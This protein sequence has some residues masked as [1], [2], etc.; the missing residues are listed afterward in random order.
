M[1]RFDGE[2]HSIY[3]LVAAQIREFEESTEDP[4]GAGKAAQTHAGA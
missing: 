2:L 1:S 4:R 3:I